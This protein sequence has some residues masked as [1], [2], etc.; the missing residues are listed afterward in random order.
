MCVPARV[1]G[2]VPGTP[3]S[4]AQRVVRWARSSS[5]VGVSRT[6]GIDFVVGLPITLSM[7]D[8]EIGGISSTEGG[9][10]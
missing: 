2:A 1:P 4:D 10:E 5:T 3:A 6:I 7:L 8:G 9:D